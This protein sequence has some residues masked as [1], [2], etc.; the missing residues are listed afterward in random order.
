MA[1]FH[2]VPAYPSMSRGGLYGGAI[3]I[4]NGAPP[5][6]YA[7]AAFINGEPGSFARL[8]GVTVLRAVFVIPGLWMSAKVVPGVDLGLFQ[9][10]LMGVAASSTISAG[11]VVWY[12]LKMKNHQMQVPYA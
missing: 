5:S 10:T 11:L 8:V 9:A 1:K 12:W 4:E 7:V 3:P 6:T 2:T